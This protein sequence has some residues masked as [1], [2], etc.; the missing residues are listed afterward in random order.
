MIQASVPLGLDEIEK[1]F[2]KFKMKGLLLGDQEAVKLMDTTLEQGRSNIISAGLKKTARS[3]RIL[4][5]LQK[6]I[7]CIEASYPPDISAGRRGDHRRQSVDRALQAKDR[8][9]CTYCSY[10]SFCQFDE[11]LEETNTEY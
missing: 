1:R 6:R 2:Q 4:T 11:S 7:S 3:V 9:P 10:R 5:L 8:T